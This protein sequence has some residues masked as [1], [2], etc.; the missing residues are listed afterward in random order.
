LTLALYMDVQV[1][2]AITH[3]L[4]L[5]GVAVLTAQEDGTDRLS[6][7]ELLDRAMQLGRVLFTRDED[8]LIEAAR[9]QQAGE[10]FAGVVY[11]HLLRATIGQCVDDLELLAKVYD[12]VHMMNAVEYLPL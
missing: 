3:G 8:F 7:P 9:R 10:S 11:A 12:P 5:R 1:Q 4:R 2:H 6:D